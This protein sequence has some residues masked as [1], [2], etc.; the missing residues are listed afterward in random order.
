[1]KTVISKWVF[2]AAVISAISCNK[3]DEIK[4]N[5]YTY[6]LEPVSSSKI[7]NG[8]QYSFGAIDF[9]N[10]NDAALQIKTASDTANCS[11]WHV[12]LV[13]SN[14][15]MYY[16]P[17]VGENKVTTYNTYRNYSNYT[18]TLTIVVSRVSGPVEKYASVIVK[19]MNWR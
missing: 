18:K 2:A 15:D 11:Q 6:V 8:D 5:S 4:I 10:A 9:S 1:M 14:G 19:R 12:Y 16:V 3:K 17:G 7:F 13:S